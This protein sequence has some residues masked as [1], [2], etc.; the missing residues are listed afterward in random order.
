MVVDIFITTT[1][2]VVAIN[3]N[4]SEL[5]QNKADLR[6]HLGGVAS[7]FADCRFCCRFSAI[8]L[9][10]AQFIRNGGSE[11]KPVA[12]TGFAKDNRDGEVEMLP[13]KSVIGGVGM[14]RL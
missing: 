13:L 2:S 1:I 12:I 5:V 14:L 9:V 8:A 3:G 6:Y 7:R 10:E 4:W 11:T